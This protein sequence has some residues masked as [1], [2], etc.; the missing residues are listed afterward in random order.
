MLGWHFVQS[1]GRLADAVKGA[2]HPHCGRRVYPG[3]TLEVE[4]VPVPDEWGLHCSFLAAN[5]VFHAPSL[6]AC[7]V[8]LGGRIAAREREAA[9]QK[10]TVLWMADA[11]LPFW[12]WACQS[13]AIHIK[14]ERATG[15]CIPATLDRMILLRYRLAQGACCVGQFEEARGPARQDCRRLAGKTS[16]GHKV[17]GRDAAPLAWLGDMVA[18]IASRDHQAA[19]RRPPW[20]S[21]SDLCRHEAARFETMMLALEPENAPCRI[22][23]NA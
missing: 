10:R 20:W 1:D 18:G 5:A 7:R 19:A 21:K 11:T 8:E 9:A 22:E 16:Q 13:A 6:L 17:A 2:V 4:G 23:V 15:A 3:L 14:R 12:V